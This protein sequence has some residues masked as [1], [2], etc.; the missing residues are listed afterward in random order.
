[1]IVATGSRRSALL[2]PLRS[3]R[4]SQ[5]ST[6]PIPVEV[7]LGTSDELPRTCAVNLDTIATIPKSSLRDRL[8]T[9]SVERMAEVEEAL[10]FALGMGA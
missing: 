2:R 4:S 3:D 7:E 6:A 9:L 1:M 5:G 10:R 8:T